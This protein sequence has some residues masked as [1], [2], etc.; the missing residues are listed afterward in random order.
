MSK[1]MFWTL[2]KQAWR[3]SFTEK[4]VKKAFESTGIWLFNPEKTVK[5]L[6]KPDPP[7]MTPVPACIRTI[8]TPLDC[9]ELRQLGKLSPTLNHVARLQHFAMIFATKFELIKHEN[10]QLKHALFNEKQRRARS[11]RLGLT[12]EAAT[13]APEFYSPARVLKAKEFQKTKAATEQEETR[14]KAL[15]KAEKE[16]TRVQKLAEQQKAKLQKE[17]AQALKK[18]QKETEQAQKR[19]AIEQRKL[20]RTLAKQARE[21]AT[22]QKKLDAATRKQAAAAAAVAGGQKSVKKATSKGP[23]KAARKLANPRPKY[24]VRLSESETAARPRKR[25]IS[26]PPAVSTLAAAT[27]PSIRSRSGRTLTRPYRF[28]D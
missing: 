5:K 22:A 3:T 6:Q 16:R 15:Q 27:G 24:A 18:E 7:S 25:P 26:N 19:A 11:K 9:R 2:F 20:D 23:K 10:G 4:N 28:E 8:L 13:G 12:G 14:L 17:M 1:R 21:L